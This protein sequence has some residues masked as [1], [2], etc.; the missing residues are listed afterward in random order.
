MS[1]EKDDIQPY[2][3]SSLEKPQ[4]IHLHPLAHLP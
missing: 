1:S 3:D 4:S 2:I